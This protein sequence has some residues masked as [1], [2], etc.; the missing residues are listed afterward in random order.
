MITCIYKYKYNTILQETEKKCYFPVNLLLSYCYK[1]IYDLTYRY[2][3]AILISLHIFTTK[4]IKLYILSNFNHGTEGG[5]PIPAT[6]RK[7]EKTN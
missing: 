7:A 1:D 6:L 2:L 3:F 5:S 4:Y